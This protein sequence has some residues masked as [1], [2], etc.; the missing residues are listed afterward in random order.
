M[1]FGLEG[2][3]A[4]VVV[5]VVDGGDVFLGLEFCPGKPERVK[6]VDTPC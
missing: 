1:F 6:Y 5:A 4:V 2:V 3:L